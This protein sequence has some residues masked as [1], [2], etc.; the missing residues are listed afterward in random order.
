MEQERGGKHACGRT[1]TQKKR[2]EGRVVLVGDASR[3]WRRTIAIRCRCDADTRLW[4][5]D[6][7]AT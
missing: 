1:I 2:R 3:G 7:G 4:A 6:R 5:D